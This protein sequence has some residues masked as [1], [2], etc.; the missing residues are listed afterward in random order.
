M[1]YGFGVAKSTVS[2]TFQEVCNDITFPKLSTNRW[3]EIAEGFGRHAEF[4][5]CIGG[6]ERYHNRMIQSTHN[7]WILYNYKQYS[8]VCGSYSQFAFTDVVL[9]GKSSESGIWQ[10]FILYGE[11]VTYIKY[12]QSITSR[13]RSN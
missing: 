4:P 10:N 3:L 5:H 13:R 8:S 6:L 9:H 12:S 7:G 1:Y 2:L 11:M